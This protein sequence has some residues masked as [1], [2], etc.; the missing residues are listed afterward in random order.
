MGALENVLSEEI[1]LPSRH[2]GDLRHHS[3]NSPP[4]TVEPSVSLTNTFQATPATTSPDDKNKVIAAAVG[5]T[6]TSL[7]SK[8]LLLQRP[9]SRAGLS[10]FRA[11]LA[12]RSRT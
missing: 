1:D 11:A 10:T 2:D 12:Q 3:A 5:A 9:N 8:S 6:L 4:S 7:T